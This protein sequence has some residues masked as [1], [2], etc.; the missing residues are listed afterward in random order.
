MGVTLQVHRQRI[1]TFQPTVIQQTTDRSVSSSSYSVSKAGILSLLVLISSTILS[2]HLNA[3]YSSQICHISQ[4]SNCTGSRQLYKD[5]VSLSQT[6]LQDQPSWLS[7]RDR[8]FFARMINGNRAQRGHGIKILHWNKGPS[9]L[10]NKHNDIETVIGGHKPHILGLSEA[11][12]KMEHDLAGVQH[13]DYV[14]HTS[15][16]LQNPDLGIARVVVYTHNSLVVKRRPDLE[17]DTVSA[18]WLECG[19]P[20]QRKILVCHAYREW[21]HLGQADMSSGTLAAQLHRWNILLNMWEKA[22]LEGKEVILMMDA[23]LDFLKWTRDD[24]PTTDSTKRLKPLIEQLFSKIFPHGVSQLVTVPTRFWPGTPGSGLDHIYTNK[25]SKL[26]EVHT[27]FQGGSDHKLLKITR[28]SKSLRK[29]VRYVRK[30]TFKNF[31]DEDFCHAVDQ[32]SWWDIYS[33]QDANQAASLLTSKLTTILDAMAPIRTIQ[34]RSNY[35]PWLSDKT[36]HLLK[37]RN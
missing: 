11:N 35:A 34:V 17:D 5:N 37:E 14:L 21:Q 27:E 30:R 20:R 9:F 15:P 22:L 28:Y 2:I 32:L 33:C 12:F 25:P 18:I 8:N 4:P 10:H 23:N 24:L 26:S 13:S 6:K 16:T 7:A 31:K 3:A 29:N 1:G 19:L 36:K